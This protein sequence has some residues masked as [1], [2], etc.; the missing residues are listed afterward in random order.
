MRPTCQDKNVNQ[1]AKPQ[2]RLKEVLALRVSDNLSLSEHQGNRL[3][4]LPTTACCWQ[5]KFFVTL[6]IIKYAISIPIPSIPKAYS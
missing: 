4:L 6:Y 1:S 5:G 3:G 2:T